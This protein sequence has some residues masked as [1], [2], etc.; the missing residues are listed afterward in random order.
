MYSIVLFFSIV[1]GGENINATITGKMI[2]KTFETESVC[3]EEKKFLSQQNLQN[4]FPKEITLPGTLPVAQTMTM[5]EVTL[6]YS[7]VKK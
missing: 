5:Q 3:L 1:T 6:V 2:G 7:C 4:G